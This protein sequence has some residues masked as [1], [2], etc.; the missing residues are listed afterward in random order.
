VVDPRVVVAP[1][2]DVPGAGSEASVEVV[3]GAASVVA[4]SAP[5]TARGAGRVV[6]VGAV[7]EGVASG[8]ATTG[9]PPSFRNRSRTGSSTSASATLATWKAVRS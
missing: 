9:P 8:P 2:T 3:V 1:A 7:V 4:V 6:V 5:P